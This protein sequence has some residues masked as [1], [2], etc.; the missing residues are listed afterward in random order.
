MAAS[1]VA[2]EDSVADEFIDQFLKKTNDIAIG[3]GLDDNVFMGPVIRK[4]HKE[5]TLSYIEEGENKGS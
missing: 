1:V 5:R 3:N 4:E 2:V